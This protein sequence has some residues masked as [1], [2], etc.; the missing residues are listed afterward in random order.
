[1]STP[2]KK[3]AKIYNQYVEK[4]YRYVFLK[5]SSKDVAE[6]LTSDIFT[7]LWRTFRKGKDKEIEN[8]RAFIYKVA[9]N[10]LNI[11]GR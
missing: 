9:R 3:F 7:K 5:V 2:K 1:M 10:T 8:P 11:L 6:D 4:V